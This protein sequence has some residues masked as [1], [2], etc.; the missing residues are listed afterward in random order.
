MLDQEDLHWLAANASELN[1]LLQE[2]SRSS[3]QARQHKE[4]KYLDLLDEEVARA[5]RSAQAI[6]ERV[7]E[8]GLTSGVTGFAPALPAP[9]PSAAPP[10][11]TKI[12]V[13]EVTLESEGASAPVIRNPQGERE[14]ILLVDDDLEVLERTGE[15]LDFEDYRVIPVKDGLEALRIYRQMGKEI[16]LILLDYFLPVMDGDAVFDEL[17]AINPEVRV[18]LSSGFGEQAKVA[19]MLAHGLRG[20]IPKP[21]TH[22][23]LVEQIRSILDA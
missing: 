17:Q 16:D 14:L 22:E 9:R 18:V 1:L 2:V 8:N 12:P 20:F 23:K 7:T 3:G 21:Y 19:G 5:A 4:D 15:I 6:F 10:E 13:G 11:E